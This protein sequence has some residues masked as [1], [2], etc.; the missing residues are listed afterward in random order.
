ML[1]HDT[2][3]KQ[4][5]EAFPEAAYLAP[6]GFSKRG[7]VYD[8]ACFCPPPAEWGNESRGHQGW[9]ACPA[10][11]EHAVSCTGPSRTLIVADLLFNFGPDAP[12]VDAAADA[13]WRSGKKHDPGMA[14]SM[15][16]SVKDDGALRRSLAA[17][18]AAW[19]FDRIIVG[20]GEPSRHRRQTPLRRRPCVRRAIEK[21]FRPGRT[22]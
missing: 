19:D 21:S 2:F 10:M 3:A 14:R 13:G 1:R 17:V 20:H 11:E 4:G 7:G 12:V 16:M 15:R 5:R 18:K 22:S 8:R 9:T 6:E